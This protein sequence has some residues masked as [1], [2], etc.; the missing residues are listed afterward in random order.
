[1]PRP[2]GADDRDHIARSGLQ[3]PN[4]VVGRAGGFD[5]RRFG[6]PDVLRHD[7]EVHHGRDDVLRLGPVQLDAEDL[8]PRAEVDPPARQKRQARQPT[9]GLT[10]T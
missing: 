6:E 2:A 1:M 3:G 9:I 7:G 4:G 8:A 10:K 5:E